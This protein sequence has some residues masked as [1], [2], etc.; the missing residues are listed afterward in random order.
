MLVKTVKVKR[1]MLHLTEAK[2]EEEVVK[3]KGGAVVMEEEAVV[4]Q[5]GVV[6][7]KQEA[8]DARQPCGQQ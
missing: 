6:V 1:K 2:D 3:V 5:Q 4:V 7:V 8:L